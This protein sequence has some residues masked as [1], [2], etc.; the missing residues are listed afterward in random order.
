MSL[1]INAKSY[2]ADSVSADAVKYA[3]PA[4]TLSV[5]DVVLLARQ[6][7]KPTSL[8]SGVART[9]AKLTRTATLTGALTSTGDAIFNVQG[10]W[11]VG[12]ASADIDAVCAD[13]GA[14]IA[15][16]EFKDIVKKLTVN[17]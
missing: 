12:M 15:S 4:N 3:G 11:P 5:K 16:T 6:Q 7:P 9:T 8:F 14:W 1:T 10:S 2:S 13:F 17:K